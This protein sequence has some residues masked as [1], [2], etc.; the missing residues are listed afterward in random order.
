MKRDTVIICSVLVLCTGAILLHQ[1]LPR[2]EAAKQQRIEAA[3]KQ[4]RRLEAEECPKEDV[5]R[6]L[7]TYPEHPA[8]AVI[9]REVAESAGE[10]NPKHMQTVI[11]ICLSLH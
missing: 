2:W 8:Y 5:I 3:D 1:Q 4:L 10:Y 7:Q 6:W 9:N 11:N